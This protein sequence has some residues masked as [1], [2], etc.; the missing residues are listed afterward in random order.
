MDIND[1]TIEQI[2]ARSAEIDG[3]VTRSQDVAEIERLT[4]EL[5]DLLERKKELEEIEKR[6]NAAQA[7]T[8]GKAE[9]TNVIEKREEKKM[10]NIDIRKS[11]EYG[12][13]YVKAIM[14]GDDKEARALLSANA[15]ANGVIPVPEMLDTEIRNAWEAAQVMSLVK[16]TGYI[17][18]VKVG[19]EYSA[20]GASVHLEGAEAPEEEKLVLGIVE[21]KAQ[22]IRKWITISDEAIE[23]TT[24]DTLGY[25]YKEIAQKI[26]EKAEEILVGQIVAAPAASTKTAP[27]VP[28]LSA[29]PAVDT[30]VKAVALLSAQAKDLHVIMNRQTYAEF[31][32]IAL[33]ANYPVDVFDGLRERVVFSDKL[34]AFSAASV[35]DVYAIV[36]D[37]AYGAQANFPSGNEM[38]VKTDDI[39]LSE[40]GLVKVTGKQ[41]IGTAVV[42]PG[43]F[44]NIKKVSAE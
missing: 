10:E 9:P 14:T 26:V 25:I 24:I 2:E 42:A 3:I 1:M 28:V 11:P 35:S 19:F 13:A 36:G 8:V 34:K 5:S 39:S 32:S 43:A 20:D 17:G 4:K 33:K 37:F 38:T 21:I 41:Y 44:V 18:N 12:L 6:R 29:N 23:G 22:S 30:I 40:K 27:G 16:K 7:L 31:V 15:S